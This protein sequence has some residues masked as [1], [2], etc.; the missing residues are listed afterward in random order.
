MNQKISSES[1]FFGVNRIDLS[2]EANTESKAFTSKLRWENLA[3]K[4]ITKLKIL[5]SKTFEYAIKCRIKHKICQQEPISPYDLLMYRGEY[6]EETGKKNYKRLIQKIDQEL[7]AMNYQ[8]GG[9]DK[10]LFS[11]LFLQKLFWLEKQGK[12]RVITRKEV[13]ERISIDYNSDVYLFFDSYHFFNGGHVPYIEQTIDNLASSNE[14]IIFVFLLDR[15]MILF[16]SL[17][18]LILNKC[19]KLIVFDATDFPIRLLNN[20]N[21]F[22]TI[23]ELEAIRNLNTSHSIITNNS[24]F[25]PILSW[26]TYPYE[27]NGNPQKAWPSAF[28]KSE[29]KNIVVRRLCHLP[30]AQLKRN[31]VVIHAR[32]STLMS[33]NSRNTKP[34]IERGKLLREIIKMGLQ[35]IVLGVMEPGTKFNHPDIFY[36][37]ELG[38]ITDDIQIHMLH[39]AI[40][41]IGSPSGV[42]H[43]TYCT[44]TPLLLLDMPY[45]FCTSYPSSN[46]KALMKKLKMNSCSI[47]LAKY[48]EYS[49]EEL[50]EEVRDFQAYSP[51]N[52]DKIELECNSDG[53]ILHA[54]Q[55]LLL[56]TY[57]PVALQDLNIEQTDQS[58]NFKARK[59]DIEK[60]NS[61]LKECKKQSYPLPYFEIRDL[62]MANWYQD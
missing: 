35:V 53:A 2:F 26:R 32:N 60:I 29:S 13:P 38:P 21:Q 50:Q 12:L 41:F 43:L 61:A 1:R 39:G 22:Y 57:S 16:P 40:G 17:S 14:N 6:H 5:V 30:E 15:G 62:S 51:L 45:P 10:K 24:I 59:R 46:M 48:Y 20:L 55:E 34:W 49:Q 37:D 28:T 31:Y 19:D 18:K 44:D 25:N 47:S 36:A 4:I 42:T 54:F 56:E 27:S 11:K 33:D 3:L 58:I 23:S 9:V 8:H 7:P 52:R